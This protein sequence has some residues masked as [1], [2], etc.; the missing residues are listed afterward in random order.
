MT[1]VFLVNPLVQINNKERIHFLRDYAGG[2]IPTSMVY[3][4][5]DLA[6]TAALLREHGVSVSLLD[7]STLDIAV[8]ELVK[9]AVK[10]DPD[11][12]GIPS[13]WGSIQYDMDLSRY[14]KNALPDAKIIIWGPNVTAG[15]E[16]ALSCGHIDYVILGEP[17]KPFLDIVNGMFTENIAYQTCGKLVQTKRTLL[18]DLD[19]LPFPARDLLPNKRYIAPYAR[20]NP[21]TTISTSRGCPY[22]KC[23]FCPTNIWYMNQVRYRSVGNV[24]EEIDE[25]VYKYGIRSLVF[26]D[27]SLTFERE[28]L[29]NICEEIIRRDYPLSWRCFAGVGGINMELLSIMKR[30]GCYQVN[31]GFESGSQQVLDSN[32][33]GVTLK[34]SIDAVRFTKAA[35]MEV[36]G[37]FMLGM[38]GDNESTIKNTVDFAIELDLDYAEFLVATPLPSTKFYELSGLPEDANASLT[39]RWYNRSYSSN[40]LLSAGFLDKQIKRAYRR[41][42]FRPAYI[43]KRSCRVSSSR[44]L[45]AQLK[46][47]ASLFTTTLSR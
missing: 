21:F 20:E 33:K 24:M 38:F 42:Y 35:G 4:P 31:Y 43:F 2:E 37:S 25:I 1:K 15:P 44:Q 11:F 7:A 34:E 14:F 29:F 22:S 46:S 23:I 10:E 32:N 36:S 26:R 16:T 17:E 40:S 18:Q 5:L 28:R 12:I 13:A 41:F 6:Y 30:A 39:Q 27:Q 19:S 8:P 45:I 47:A 3:P 9:T